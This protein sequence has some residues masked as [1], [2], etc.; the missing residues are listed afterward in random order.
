MV[1]KI[2]LHPGKCV[3]LKEHHKNT[4]EAKMWDCRCSFKLARINKIKMFQE[5]IG[6][7][8]KQDNKHTKLQFNKDKFCYPGYQKPNLLCS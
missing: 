2:K 5:H 4:K 7:L 3:D 8:I 6:K 1:Y